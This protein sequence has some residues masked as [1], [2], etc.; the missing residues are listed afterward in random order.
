MSPPMRLPLLQT[1]A[2]CFA[3]SAMGADEVLFNRDVQ[4]ILS[5]KCFACHGFD[6]KTREADLRLDSFEGAT[7]DSEGVRAIVPGDPAKSEAWAR[8]ITDDE[9]DLMPPKKSHKK[10]SDREKAVLKRWIEQGAK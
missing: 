10:L 2:V 7:K 5:D 8:I 1:F 9:D 4:P 6:E 3:A